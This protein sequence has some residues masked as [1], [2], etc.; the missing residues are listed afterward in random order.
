M[1]TLTELLDDCKNSYVTLVGSIRTLMVPSNKRLES[2]K[3]FRDSIVEVVRSEKFANSIQKELEVYINGNNKDEDEIRTKIVKSLLLE[4]QGVT[5]S[6]EI[7][8][9][10]KKKTRINLLGASS[11]VIGSIKD[12]CDKNDTVKLGLTV[13]NEAIDL[14][15]G[16]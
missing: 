9:F 15:K 1:L 7:S 16:S 12:F 14:F 3:Q 6:I 13:F 4:I 5:N 11:T 2:H 8:N 10:Q